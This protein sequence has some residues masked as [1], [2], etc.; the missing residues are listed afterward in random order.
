MILTS[1][2]E[3]ASETKLL[4]SQEPP[5]T[6]PGKW[7]K[8]CAVSAVIYEGHHSAVRGDAEFNRTH[9]EW[10]VPLRVFAWLSAIPLGLF[11]TNHCPAAVR[12]DLFNTEVPVPQGW[13]AGDTE[14]KSIKYLH[15]FD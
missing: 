4:K 13:V 14:D 1:Q 10:L 15:F 2:S 3:I 5:S 7:L 11:T 12:L 9:A 8:P 6:K